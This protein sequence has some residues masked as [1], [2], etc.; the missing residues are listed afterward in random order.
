MQRTDMNRIGFGANRIGF[1][2]DEIGCDLYKYLDV[3]MYHCGLY[4]YQKSDTV[5]TVS[6]LW[7]V[8]L[9]CVYVYSPLSRVCSTNI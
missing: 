5:H 8:S 9:F 7:T 2:V 1:G 6:L 3:H 4:M